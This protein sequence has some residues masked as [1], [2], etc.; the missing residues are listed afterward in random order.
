MQSSAVRCVIP[1]GRPV[2]SGPRGSA[3]R[4]EWG[5]VEG[6]KLPVKGG[7]LEGELW[8]A[9]FVNISIQP[10]PTTTCL[11]LSPSFQPFEH[12]R[13]HKRMPPSSTA[14]ERI[15]ALSQH[16]HTSPNPQE[17]AKIMATESKPPI[18]CHVLDTTIGKPAAG[19]PVTL[20]FH[21]SADPSHPSSANPKIQFTSLTN[22]DV[23]PPPLLFS[24]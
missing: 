20:T 11:G 3:C 23:C 5:G 12:T 13:T 1:F 2:E 16:L 18:T 9:M 22:L 8:T 14:N 21:N 4:V 15:S 7:E 19:I 10:L 6:R 24:T 17:S